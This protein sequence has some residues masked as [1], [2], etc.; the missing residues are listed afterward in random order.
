MRTP[1]PKEFTVPF[2]LTFRAKGTMYNICVG[3]YNPYYS[4][5]HLHMRRGISNNFFHFL[6]TKTIVL[7]W[8]RRI[9]RKKWVDMKGV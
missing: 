6:P 9:L 5:L 4:Y 7:N 3:S 2:N 1:E 8:M